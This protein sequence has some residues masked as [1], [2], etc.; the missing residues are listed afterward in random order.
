MLATV[1]DAT[2]GDFLRARISIDFLHREV[3]DQPLTFAKIV[4]NGKNNQLNL[5]F[6]F[7]VLRLE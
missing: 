7:A 1:K 5:K 3:F 4:N 6:V 2:S